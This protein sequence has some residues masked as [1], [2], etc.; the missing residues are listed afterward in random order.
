MQVKHLSSEFIQGVYVC[1]FF[2]ASVE[3]NAGNSR[4]SPAPLT[5]K[6]LHALVN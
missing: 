6:N 1:V 2:I 5:T 3:N 4:L